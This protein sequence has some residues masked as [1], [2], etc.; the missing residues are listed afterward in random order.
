MPQRTAR[1]QK[2]PGCGRSRD[3]FWLPGSVVDIDK[4][5]FRVAVA[6]TTPTEGQQILTRA[7]F[8][9]NAKTNAANK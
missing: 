6:G 8:F 7:K 4:E 3:P 1:S 9:A 5:G 2:D